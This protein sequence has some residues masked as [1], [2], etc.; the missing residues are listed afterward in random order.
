MVK[1]LLASNPKGLKKGFYSQ[2]TE[3]CQNLR[4]EGLIISDP[5]YI[6]ISSLTVLNIKQRLKKSILSDVK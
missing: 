5:K 3:D 1:L 2:G 4:Y 6:A